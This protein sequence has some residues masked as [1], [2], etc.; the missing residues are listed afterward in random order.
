MLALGDSYNNFC[1][2]VYIKLVKNLEQQC[3]TFE[4][5]QLSS[6]K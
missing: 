4:E 1:V 2:C 5:I 6:S 3:P